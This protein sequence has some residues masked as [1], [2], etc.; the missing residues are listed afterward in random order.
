MEK[1]IGIPKAMYFF[2]YGD[3]WC[4]FFEAL[5]YRVILSGDTDET[6]LSLGTE[7]ASSDLCLPVKTLFGHIIALQNCA[8]KPDFIFLPKIYK[9]DKHCF[10]CPKTIG[11][12]DMVK[13][14]F[15]N[16]PKIIDSEF[17]GD[18]KPFLL[19]AAD[20]IGESRIHARSAYKKIHKRVNSDEPCA[21]TP[22][23]VALIGHSYI[24]ED[25]YL[26]MNIKQKLRDMGVGCIT[27]R[28]YSIR[29][30]SECADKTSYKNPFWH[31]ANQNLGFTKFVIDN[32]LA[33]GIIYLNSFGCGTDS[34]S[35]PFCRDY[36]RRCS[37]LPAITISVDE[38]RA[39]AGIITR[40]EAF[41]DCLKYHICSV[42]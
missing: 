12:T 21:E 1:T 5:G 29:T 42:S 19:N 23:K 8:E 17:Y 10:T 25:E 39:D 38:H 34:L 31:S 11:I 26:N 37:S 6:I 22:L 14:H 16:L 30:I 41:T 35:L 4:S 18:M 27:P 20:M 28:D 13:S 32:N 24:L 7:N 9:T 3:V 2:D 15:N 36:I 33:D 40:L